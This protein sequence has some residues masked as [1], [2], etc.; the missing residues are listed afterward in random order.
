MTRSEIETELSS[1]ID[2]ESHGII[3]W[4][5]GAEM[6]PIA[7]RRWSSFERRRKSKHPNHEERILDLAKGLQSHFEPEISYT[8]MSYWLDLAAKLSLVFSRC[9]K[10][11]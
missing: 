4:W 5:P 6:A 11:D 10:S 9:Y 2:A 8:P 7:F 3:S 1:A